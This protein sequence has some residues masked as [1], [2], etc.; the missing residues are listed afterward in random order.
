MS[1]D[2]LMGKS[3]ESRISTYS[4]MGIYQGA[5]RTRY[6]NIVIICQCNGLNIFITHIQQRDFVT[7]LARNNSN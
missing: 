7:F 3:P 6:Y 2:S 1:T 5:V 4:L